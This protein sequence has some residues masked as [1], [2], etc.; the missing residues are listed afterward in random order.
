MLELKYSPADS[1]IFHIVTIPVQKY[2][3]GKI[4]NMFF[5][6]NF[7]K[8]TESQNQVNVQ[9]VK[10]Y[11]KHNLSFNCSTEIFYLFC[12]RRHSQIYVQICSKISA[13]K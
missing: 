13:Q 10:K 12:L 7:Y 11:Q 6:Y 1:H 9:K 4:A 3:W 8:N 2:N 5:S